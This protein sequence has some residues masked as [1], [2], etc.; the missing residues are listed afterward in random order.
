MVCLCF[1]VPTFD[2]SPSLYALTSKRTSVKV[3]TTRFPID[4]FVKDGDGLRSCSV[5]GTID[6]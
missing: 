2:Q 5:A 1:A 3:F 4:D 6:V